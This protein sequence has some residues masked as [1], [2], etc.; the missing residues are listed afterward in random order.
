MD[1]AGYIGLSR[2]T[3]LMRELNTIANNLANMN[4]N[5]YR[6]EGSIF[7]EHVKSLQG[8]DPSLSIATMNKRFIDTSAGDVTVTG[9]SLD[10]AL[11]GQGFFLVETPAG[12]RLTRDGAFSLNAERAL[13]ST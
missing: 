3:G 2:Q 6:R 8:G 12:E 7:A 13:V 1:N 11:E 5:G 10:L 9:G 4:T